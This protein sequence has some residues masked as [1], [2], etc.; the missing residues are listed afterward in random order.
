M[1]LPAK[2]LRRRDVDVSN[3][4]A[5]EAL[6]QGS[7]APGQPR[8]QGSPAWPIPSRLPGLPRPVHRG[9][10]LFPFSYRFARLLFTQLRSATQIQ[11]ELPPKTLRHTH[12]VRAYRRGEDKDRIFDRIGLAQKSRFEADELHTRLA[13]RGM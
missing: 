2:R 5:P 10:Q 9:G 1:I 13:Q 4:Y 7:K 6:D 8:P 11:K 3:P 12:V